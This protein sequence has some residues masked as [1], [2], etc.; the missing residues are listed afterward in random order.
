MAR[1]VNKEKVF[2]HAPLL[3]S[4]GSNHV[5]YVSDFIAE[6]EKNIQ[7]PKKKIVNIKDLFEENHKKIE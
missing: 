4:L 6:M 3:L 5:A 2:I 7:K 1:P